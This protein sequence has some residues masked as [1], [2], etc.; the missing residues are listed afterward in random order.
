M[1]EEE[2]VPCFGKQPER[3]VAKSTLSPSASLRHAKDRFTPTCLPFQDIFRSR[4]DSEKCAGDPEDVHA[5]GP[6]FPL[7]VGTTELSPIWNRSR[8]QVSKQVDKVSKN[9]GFNVVD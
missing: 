9:L 5:K 7:K 6:L 3:Q 1:S 8:I 2:G 4:P